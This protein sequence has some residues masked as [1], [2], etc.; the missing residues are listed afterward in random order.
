MKTGLLRRRLLIALDHAS[1]AHQRDA[2]T[3][4]LVLHGLNLLTKGLKI[5]GVPSIDLGRNRFAL[6]VRE[7]PTTT[8]F[9]PGLPSRLYP[10]AANAL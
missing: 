8:C 1:V 7:Q 5:R 10:Q 2:G 3:A 9:F 6:A 4:Q